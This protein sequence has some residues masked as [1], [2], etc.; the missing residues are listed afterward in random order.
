MNE[1]KRAPQTDPQGI[2]RQTV[3]TIAC[4]STRFAQ[5]LTRAVTY[6][7]LSCCALMATTVGANAAMVTVVHGINGVDLGLAANLPVDIA[8]NGSCAIK[9]LTFTQLTRV[10]LGA[11][12][13]AITVHPASGSCTGAPVI[14][15][16]VAVSASAR[17]I[18][19]VA[20]LSDA[21]SPQLAVFSNDNEFSRSVTVN[22]AAALAP[23]FA[24][25][26]PSSWI[27]YYGKP[28]SNGSGIMVLA[29]PTPSRIIVRLFR[30]NAR[31]RLFNESIR[32]T[33]ARVYYVV[34]SKK[35]GLRV[36]VDTAM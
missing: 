22:N 11:G 5:R 21:G 36:V 6:L 26:G 35:N 28:L 23:I 33:S 2:N 15:Q 19:I 12:S 18:G 25:A 27:G 10:Q 17:R 8:V 24:G 30:S 16:T 20:N 14:R 1:Q 3:T 34:G 29:D 31:T 7:A 13:Y 4:S 32:V 9:G